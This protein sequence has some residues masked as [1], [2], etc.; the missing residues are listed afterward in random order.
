[1]HIYSSSRVCY[2]ATTGHTFSPQNSAKTR[3]RERERES[4]GGGCTLYQIEAL[5]DDCDHAE[6]QRYRNERPGGLREPVGERR[7]RRRLP[8]RRRRGS[9]R[10]PRTEEEE[11]RRRRR[12]RTAG[13][14]LV[15]PRRSPARLR[16][17][18]QSQELSHPPRPPDDALHGPAR[19][20]PRR[21]HLPGEEGAEQCARDR[22]VGEATTVP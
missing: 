18:A 17:L 1:M 21:G 7:R 6:L 3:R 14:I 22:R 2:L 5:C 10:G 12:R 11:R 13:I 20:D 19:R 16:R 9:R 8:R 15:V 4:G